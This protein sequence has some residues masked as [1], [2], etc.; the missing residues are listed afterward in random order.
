MRDLLYWLTLAPALLGEPG[1]VVIRLE[2]TGRPS[3]AFVVTGWEG[4]ASTAPGS[5]A[6]RLAV[7]VDSGSAAT[8]PILGAHRVENGAL[9]FEPRFRLEP[10]L[11]YRALFRPAG[12]GNPV[13]TTFEIPKREAKPPA[14]VA[15][16]YPTTGVLPENQLKLYL[17]FSAPMSRGE[18][19]RR[20]Q[21]LD[22]SGQPVPLP[23]LELE[24][25]LWDREGKRLTLLFDPGRIKRGLAPREEVGPALSE[26][27]TYTLVIDGGWPDADGSPLAQEFRKAFRAGPADREPLD[28]KTWRLGIPRAGTREPLSVEFPEPLDQALLAGL[29]EVEDAPG[30]P[31]SG[32][33]QIDRQETRWRFTP[34]QPWSAG[35]YNLEA[36]KTIEDL[37]GNTIG[38]PFEVDVFER[39][40]ERIARETARIPFFIRR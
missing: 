4:A 17:H 24:Q 22:Q 12:G 6:D 40:S 13:A 10:G 3:P 1:P 21:L 19:Y 37:A 15:Q 16:V 2:T 31:V 18:A 23:F 29:L 9:I 28:P 39:V 38:R 32:S 11:R 33:V 36:G 25:E 20:I 5:W 30:N 7:Y 14:R 34:Q 35:R 8:V 27:K 26:G